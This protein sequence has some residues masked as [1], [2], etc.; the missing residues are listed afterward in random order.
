MNDDDIKK[1]LKEL[2]IEIARL[3]RTVIY[4]CAG[5]AGFWLLLFVAPRLLAN[6]FTIAFLV[7][8]IVC[9]IVFLRWAWA[10]YR[11]KV[12]SRF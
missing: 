2:R 6:I 12:Q 1:Q 11:A 9:L 5:V 4:S 10:A 8:G 7:V 3:R